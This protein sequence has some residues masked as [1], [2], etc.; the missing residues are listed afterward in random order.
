M[1]VADVYRLL[2]RGRSKSFSLALS[3]SFATFGA[4]TVLEPPVRLVGEERIALGSR[5]FVGA[6]SWLQVIAE[7]TAAAPILT[8]GDGSKLSG[9]C[10]L[11]AAVGIDVGSSVLI[12]RGVYI[13]DHRHA[14]DRPDAAIADQ[15]LEA[16]APV[17]IGAGAWL[18]EH[19]VVCP[20]VTIGAGAVVGANSVVTSD[21]PDR[22][23]AV[24]APAR[25]VRQLA[26]GR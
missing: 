22:C 20:G 1:N 21:V 17:T 13:S 2:Q 7:G 5:C 14:F 19:V 12:A 3:R 23:V 25:V 4:H 24:G 6:G 9:G 10:T 8:I 11:S 26:A 15:G 18:G 16:L